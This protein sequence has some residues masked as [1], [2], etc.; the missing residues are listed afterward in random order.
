MGL[1][2]RRCLVIKGPLSALEGVAVNAILLHLGLGLLLEQ[3]DVFGELAERSTSGGAVAGV[4]GSVERHQGCIQ[5]Y[6]TQAS[7][8]Q[9]VHIWFI[10]T[11]VIRKQTTLHIKLHNK[12]HITLHIK[13]HFKLHIKLHN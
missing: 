5:R 7:Q 13:L 3:E 8:V 10:V 6:C 1:E 9:T 2:D 11:W 4:L 12:L